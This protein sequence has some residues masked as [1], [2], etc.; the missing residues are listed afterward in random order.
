M[1]NKLITLY[2]IRG[3]FSCPPLLKCR[4]KRITDKN[5]CKRRSWMNVKKLPWLTTELFMTPLIASRELVV[6]MLVS[7]TEMFSGPSYK[8][9]FT[10]E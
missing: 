5:S 9:K 4:W 3:N 8:R 7:A 6:R 2:S 10:L 1:Q